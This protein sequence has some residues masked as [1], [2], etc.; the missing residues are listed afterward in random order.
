M[1][2]KHSASYLLKLTGSQ[3]GRE[4]QDMFFFPDIMEDT[5]LR[6]RKS[7]HYIKKA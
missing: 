3:A 6:E 2:K 7:L 4:K 1:P 5:G